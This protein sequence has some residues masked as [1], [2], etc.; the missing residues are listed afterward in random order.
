MCVLLNGA[1]LRSQAPLMAHI[2]ACKVIVR[3]LGRLVHA[4][5]LLPSTLLAWG[6]TRG[7]IHHAE[8]GEPPSRPLTIVCSI[9]VHVL[10]DQTC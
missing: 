6:L 5:V 4:A 1:A 3:A 10:P 9:I 2:V 7:L 8:L